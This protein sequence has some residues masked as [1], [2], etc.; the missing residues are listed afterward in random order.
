MPAKKQ[1]SKKSKHTKIA[2]QPETGRS[3]DDDGR[4]ESLSQMVQT[5]SANTSNEGSETKKGA[6]EDS[7]KGYIASG[8]KKMP[9][10]IMQ[11]NIDKVEIIL[12][13]SAD[14]LAIATGGP[15]LG[16]GGLIMRKQEIIDK[17]L[18]AEKALNISNQ[19]YHKREELLNADMATLQGYA[20]DMRGS[21]M[22]MM[23]ETLTLEREIITPGKDR[24]IAFAKVEVGEAKAGYEKDI[25]EI[26]VK[27]DKDKEITNVEKKLAKVEVKESGMEEKMKMRK[28]DIKELEE[29][30]KDDMKKLEE[31]QKRIEES[32]EKRKRDLQESEE[33]RKRDLE[34][35]EEKLHVAKNTI[36]KLKERHPED[37]NQVE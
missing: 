1:S 6:H 34:E 19:A 22:E 12:E 31:K 21:L 18:E 33:K 20:A 3:N 35:L 36:R 8:I 17:L 24:D 9:S 30:R 25:A 29:K 28:D 37:D 16:R 15:A 2:P 7:W 10:Y 13:N 4:D 27:R 11:I 26:K 23:K 14:S 5:N 32:E